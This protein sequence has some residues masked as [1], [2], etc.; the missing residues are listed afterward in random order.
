MVS[1]DRILSSVWVSM[2]QVVSSGVSCWHTHVVLDW[3]V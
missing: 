2:T 1:G 3:H